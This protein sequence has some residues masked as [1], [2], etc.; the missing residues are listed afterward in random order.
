MCQIVRPWTWS[1]QPVPRLEVAFNEYSP[2]ALESP[3]L[4][5]RTLR[6]R[7]GQLHF[8]AEPCSKSCETVNDVSNSDIL[9]FTDCRFGITSLHQ[10]KW[11][12]PG[13]KNKEQDDQLK[14]ID[15]PADADADMIPRWPG[16][17]WSLAASPLWAV[18]IR[19]A[20]KSRRS[21]VKTFKRSNALSRLW[22]SAGDEVGGEGIGFRM[23]Y[24]WWLSLWLQFLKSSDVDDELVINLHQFKGWRIVRSTCFGPIKGKWLLKQK[25]VRWR[26][27]PL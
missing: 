25:I 22:K 11:L 2:P 17:S 18:A 5:K 20:R 15:S 13:N 19:F 4:I 10:H 23:I 16:R 1:M 7:L 9:T 26:H 24:I 3:G 6:L 8:I 14:S 21:F 27:L 12:G